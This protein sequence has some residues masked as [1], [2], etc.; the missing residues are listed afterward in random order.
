MDPDFPDIPLGG[1]AGTVAELDR[2][3]LPM[4]LVRLKQQTIQSIHPV[5]PMPL[6]NSLPSPE[7]PSDPMS[8]SQGTGCF[9]AGSASS[10]GD[11]QMWMVKMSSLALSFPEIVMAGLG[12]PSPCPM[13]LSNSH[14]STSS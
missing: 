7:T 3:K 5:Q 11:V 4:C 13:A 1:W 2:R 8:Y 10:G 9:S 6:Y 12:R 14:C